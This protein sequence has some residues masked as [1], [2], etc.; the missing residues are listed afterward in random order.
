MSP[1]AAKAALA[2]GLE[3]EVKGSGFQADVLVTSSPEAVRRYLETHDAVRVFAT[4]VGRFK[5]QL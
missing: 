3:G 5:R 4:D 1:E 2:D